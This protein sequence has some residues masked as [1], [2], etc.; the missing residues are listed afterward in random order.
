MNEQELASHPSMPLVGYGMDTM[1][2]GQSHDPDTYYQILLVTP[3]KEKTPA[4]YIDTTIVA[5]TK[6]EFE[7]YLLDQASK[8]K[9]Q[10]YY[11][12]RNISGDSI[13][14]Y[15]PS[16]G[17]VLS[18]GF[19]DELFSNSVSRNQIISEANNFYDSIRNLLQSRKISQLISTTW[20]FYLEAKKTQTDW[21]NFVKGEW[22]KIDVKM[23]DALIAREI[24]FVNQSN[25]SSELDPNNLDIYYPLRSSSE[26]CQNPRFMILPNSNAW[27]GIALSLL[28]AGQAYRQIGEGENVSYHQISQPILSTGEIVNR[29]GMEVEW[30]G[31]EGKIK[32][33]SMNPGGSSTAF[34][35][36]VPY[37]PIPSE[38]N[39][40]P[41]HIQKWAEADD[42]GEDFPFYSKTEDGTY[43]IYVNYVTPPYPYLPL[44][45]S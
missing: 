2:P 43:S 21:D 1:R 26:A 10:P 7:K 41:E 27:Q 18:D 30:H 22:D 14:S 5:K 19:V 11:E 8:E 37:P 16:P 24:F 20:H 6:E 31:Y 39:L 23:L 36:V 29:Y 38:I 40:P 35:V 17:V 44:T 28:M 25:S 32:E 3:P 9:L 15:L 13:G 12:D 4:K 42:E 45:S 33:L 34:Q